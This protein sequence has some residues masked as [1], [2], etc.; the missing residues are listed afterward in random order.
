VMAVMLVAALAF[1]GVKRW[2]EAV[3]CGLAVVALGTS[4]W[5]Q[6]APRT[7]L[8][9]FPVWIALARLGERWPVIRYAYLAVSAPIAVVLGTLYLS[10][11][12][13]G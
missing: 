13:A 8:V 5:Y 2:P 4:T 12:W 9:L 6:T 11:M 10:G 1:A 3:Y 7:L